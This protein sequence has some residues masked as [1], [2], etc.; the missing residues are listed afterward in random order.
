MKTTK[1]HCQE[2]LE[3]LEKNIEN[4]KNQNIKMDYNKT[5]LELQNQL[6]V[7]ENKLKT[8]TE[9]NFDMYMLNYRIE[10]FILSII[11]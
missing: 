6:Q 8:P 7:L 2:T 11:N 10:N 4:I 1:Y 5:Y 3:L 9:R